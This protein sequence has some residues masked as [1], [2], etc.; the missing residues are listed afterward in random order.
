MS[1]PD[2]LRRER[3]RADPVELHRKGRAQR[4]R[5]DPAGAGRGD[6]R[7]RPR[8]RPAGRRPGLGPVPQEL[9]CAGDGAPLRPRARGARA[10]R[11][12][13]RDRHR[14][15]PRQGHPPRRARRPDRRPRAQGAGDHPRRPRVHPPGGLGAPV[16]ERHVVVQPL[17]LAPPGRLGRDV[18]E[19]LRRGAARRRLRRHQ[20]EVLDRADRLVH[21]HAQPPGRVVGAAR[22]DPRDRAGRRRRPTGQGVAGQLRRRLRASRAATTCR[23]CAT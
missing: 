4:P 17:L 18:P 6:G 7:G 1:Q 22:P 3:R 16:Q 21:G 23:A 20:P 15:A 10:R 11:S 13:G 19:G 9:P 12:A 8:S 2:F 5:H 14:R